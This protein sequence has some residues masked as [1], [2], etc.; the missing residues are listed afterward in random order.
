MVPRS[1][2]SGF[3]FIEILFG[4]LV[5]VTLYAVAVGPTKEYVQRQKLQRCAENLRKLHLTLA[6][7][8]N[9]HE[10]AYPDATGA[11]HANE[12]FALLVPRYSTDAS[13][14]SCP[15]SGHAGYAYVAGL[16]KDADGGTMLASD[17]Q[18]STDAKTQGA[19]VFSDGDSGPGRNHGKAGGNVLFVDGH[20][21]IIGLVATH[22]LLLPAGAK[23]LNPTP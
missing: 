10:G 4:M 7:Y 14:F 12:I 6:L 11:R 19:R 16:R 15:G 18:V 2:T 1:H 20:L 23:L 3:S 22:D 5:V 21:E 13:L 9:E 8:A 17:G